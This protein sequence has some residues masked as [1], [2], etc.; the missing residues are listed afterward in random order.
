MRFV[1]G[2]A[3]Q[4]DQKSRSLVASIKWIDQ[5]YEKLIS[6]QGFNQ[7]SQDSIFASVS[8]GRLFIYVHKQKS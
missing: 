3:T 6:Y 4:Y 2:K 1:L 5:A 7:I 8:W